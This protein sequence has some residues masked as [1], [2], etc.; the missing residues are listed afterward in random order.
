MAAVLTDFTSYDEVRACLGVSEEE[1]SDE[2]LCLPLYAEAMQIELEEVSSAIPADFATVAAIAEG[3]RS[4]AENRFFAAVGLFSAYAVA[5][6][7]GTSLPLFSPKT[8]TDG[9]A[10][11]S[12]DAAAPFKETLKGVAK[13]YERF[14]SL[15]ASRYATYKSSSVTAVVL[16]FLS[17]IIPAKD[18]VI[19]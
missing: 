9:K 11:F 16:P 13:S 1:L 6:Q 5:N 14:R 12:R 8:I 18:P 3:S 2:T 7:L 17:V 4:D 10:S 19:G 15:L